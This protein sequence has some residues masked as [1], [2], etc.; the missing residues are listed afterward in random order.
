MS[1]ATT[2]FLQ[3]VLLN[4]LIAMMGQSYGDVSSV[5]EASKMKERILMIMENFFLMKTGGFNRAKYLISFA[6]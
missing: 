4:M 5:A 6:H 3:I 1:V 2:F